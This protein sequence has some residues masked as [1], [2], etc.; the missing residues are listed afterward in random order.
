MKNIIDRLIDKLGRSNVLTG[1]D[2]TESYYHIWKMEEPLRA[3]AIV[4]PKTTQE[5]ALIM[6]ICNELSQSVI[7]F[8]G[9]T[10]LVGSTE[11]L[12]NEIIISMEKM[13]HIEEVDPL[14]RTITAQAGVI[15]ENLHAAADNENMFFPLNF[16]AKGSAQLGG[17]IANNAGGLQ[18]FKFGMTRN[19]ILGLEV[20]LADGTI[21]S[22]LKKIIKDNSA[23]DLKQLFIGSEGLLGIVTKVVFKLIEAPKSRTSA[24][25]GINDYPHVMRFL[26]FMDKELAGNLSS[27]ELIWENC[28]KTMTGPQNDINPPIPYGYKYYVLL[29]ALGVDQIKD[30]ARL[31]FLL[32]KAFEEKLIVDAAI[33]D[34]SS[35]MN[36][37]WTI[38]E[39]VHQLKTVCTHDHHFDIS[40]PIP[41][42]GK[43]VDNTVKELMNIEG[44]DNVFAFGHV[45]DGNI[46]FIVDKQNISPSLKKEI[47]LVVY[48]PIKELGGSVSAE[49]G[50]GV[51]KKAYLG[52]CRTPEEIA[53]MKVL[54]KTLDPKGILNPGKVLSD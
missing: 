39:D 38:R 3:M 9:R 27:F 25:V 46:H 51:H 37:F 15:L 52:L 33:A 54:K 32:E 18:V 50:I 24:F 4:L 1:Q 14:S 10:N 19:L 47:D 35:D 6:K 20:V 11:T 26:K 34:G 5:V 7:V 23:F 22:G 2:V 28:Y 45:A 44:V 13:N 12:G 17:I 36:W 49:H 40:I 8:G 53:L 42:I 31:Q 48:T 16:G 30:Q 29:E 41:E 21:I 43:Y